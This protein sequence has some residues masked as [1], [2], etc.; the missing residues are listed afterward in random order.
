MFEIVIIPFCVVL[1]V[2]LLAVG[3]TWIE[4]KIEDKRIAKKKRMKK[5]GKTGF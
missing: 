2:L 3:L 4:I 1:L 5:I